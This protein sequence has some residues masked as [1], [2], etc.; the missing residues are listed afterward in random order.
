MHARL[1]SLVPNLSIHFDRVLIEAAYFFTVTLSGIVAVIA[2]NNADWVNSFAFMK[3]YLLLAIICLASFHAGAQGGNR[4][5]KIVGQDPLVTNE[6]E[7]ITIPMSVLYVEDR[8]DWFY[9]WGFTMQIYEGENYTLLGQVVI[10]APNF[11]GKLIVPVTVHDGTA[12]SNRFDLEIIVNAINDQP[13]ITGH[14]ALSTDEDTPLAILREHLTVVDPDNQY[15]DDFSLTVHGGSDY[16][17]TGN[18]VTPHPG[19][20]GTLTVNVSVNDGELNSDIYDLPITVKAVNRVPEITGQAALQV[21]EDAALSI[22][23]SHLTVVDND[24]NYPQGFSMRVL[25]GENYS[26]SNTSITP[27]PDF[28][29]RLTI[30][31]IVNDGVNDSKPF[32]LLVTVTPVNDVPI[33]TGLEVE[34]LFYASIDVQIPISE[35]LV[36]VEKDGDSIMFAEIGF[37]E[38]GYQPNADKL[39]YNGSNTSIRGVFDSNSGVLTLLGQGSPS[40]YTAALKSVHYQSILPVSGAK[41]KLYIKLNDGKSE[42]EA[43][44]RALLF[45]QAEIALDI[46]TGFTPNGDLSNDTWKIIPLKNEEG[47]SGA[48]IRVYNKAGVMVYESIGFESEWDGRLNGELLP[49]DTYFYTIDLNINAPEGYLKG[50]VTILR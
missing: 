18:Q 5:P 8:D 33:V 17:F 7:R 48:I 13:V 26:F 19:F 29:G 16:S 38:E 9:P 43:V 31:V 40:G 2:E 28:F 39:V 27:S 50:L 49:A 37:R 22:V 20:S 42:S 10:P 35:A 6:D 45:G 12:E 44:E 14:S 4:K 23:F 21:N 24:S 46:P 1:A 11:F 3:S 34:P 25:S 41:K 36:V 15:P 47:F 32:N 30:P